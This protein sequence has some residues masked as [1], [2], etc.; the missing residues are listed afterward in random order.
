MSSKSKSG[1]NDNGA[2]E[3]DGRGA[4]KRRMSVY[5]HRIMVLD[6]IR[7]VR[8]SKKK[9]TQK[10]VILHLSRETGIP[11]TKLSASIRGYAI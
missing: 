2:R 10:N 8:K 1:P 5:D 7:S 6:R 11:A 9:P 4:T 3:N